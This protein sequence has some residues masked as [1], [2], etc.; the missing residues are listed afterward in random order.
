MDIMAHFKHL[1]FLIMI[2]DQKHQKMNNYKNLK[3]EVITA[4][5]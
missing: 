1:D 3:N 4:L 5:L 2:G